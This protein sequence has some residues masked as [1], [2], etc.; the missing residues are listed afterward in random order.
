MHQQAMTDNLF[1][2]ISDEDGQ[3]IADTTMMLGMMDSMGMNSE[4]DMKTEY[5]THSY[6][7]TFDERHIGNIVVY[8]SHTVIGTE[9]DCLYTF[10]S[11]FYFDIFFTL[12]LSLVLMVL[13]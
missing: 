9:I 10:K 2:R 11:N 1:Y 3:I 12:D 8:Y 4:T 13:S 5:Q 6:D 7:L